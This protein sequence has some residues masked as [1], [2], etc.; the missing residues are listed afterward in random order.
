MTDVLDLHL[1][2]TDQMIKEYHK[3]LGAMDTS[4]SKHYESI[5]RAGIV[6]YQLLADDED[7]FKKGKSNLPSIDHYYRFGINGVTIADAY[8]NAALTEQRVLWIYRGAHQII[9]EV[10]KDDNLRNCIP[11]LRR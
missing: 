10:E 5:L 8:A 9:G 6:T 4:R 11:E 3:S 1:R 2:I 7:I